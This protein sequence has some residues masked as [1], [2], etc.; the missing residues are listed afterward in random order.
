MIIPKLDKE[1]ESCDFGLQENS[2]FFLLGSLGIL[3][4]R[5]TL[6]LIFRNLTKIAIFF[7]QSPTQNVVSTTST[8]VTEEKLAV[9]LLVPDLRQGLCLAFRRWSKTRQ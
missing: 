8:T 9:P 4:E 7:I 1:K 3:G 2:K 5:G 6:L